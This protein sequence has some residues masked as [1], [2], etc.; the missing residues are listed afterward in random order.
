M[1]DETRQATL[2]QYRLKEAKRS[3]RRACA[4][5]VYNYPGYT[6][7]DALDMPIGDRKLLLT[8]ARL[9]QT[10]RLLELST[11]VAASQ[12]EKGYKKISNDLKGVIKELTAQL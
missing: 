10:E 11:V 2:T 8:Y 9:H 7:E 6:L 5:L 12:S 1:D 4:E 3:E